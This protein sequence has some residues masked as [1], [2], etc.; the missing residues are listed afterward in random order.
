[1][2]RARVLVA[3]DHQILTDGLKNLLAPEFDLVGVVEDGQALL[4]AAKR[5]GPDVIVADITMP[6]MN[7]ID[8][9]IELKKEDPA[10]KVVFL[11]MHRKVAYA[12]RALKA[13]ASGFVLKQSALKELVLAIR[14]AL[15]GRPFVTPALAEDLQ[16]PWHADRSGAASNALTRRQLEVLE[17][18]AV[19]KTAKEIADVLRVSTRTVEFHKYEMMRSLGIES[20]A[21]L[22][23]FAI[24]QGIVTI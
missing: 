13:G 17:L 7:G 9:L 14:G 24:K 5:L 21:G 15:E 11:T 23:H 4:E 10:V 19:G 20:S 16:Q 6:R 18:L 2:T 3:D 1:V 22:I 8:A 12:R